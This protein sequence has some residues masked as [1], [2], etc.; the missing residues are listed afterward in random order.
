MP[1]PTPFPELEPAVLRVEDLKRYLG[2]GRTAIYA[3][4]DNDP[5][6]PTRVQ[7]GPRAVGWRRAEIDEWLATRP[8]APRSAK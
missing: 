3:L 2:L 5:S 1:T 4:C 7:L 8:P 6:F